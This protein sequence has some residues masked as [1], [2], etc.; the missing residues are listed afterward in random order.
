MLSS[1]LSSTK[2]LAESDILE[3]SSGIY[4]SISISPIF[5]CSR[6]WIIDSGA[7]SH[8]CFSKSS[9]DHLRPVHNVYVTLPNH[10][11]IL[12]SSI[13]FVKLTSEL[14]LENVLFV[15]QFQFNLLFVSTLTKNNSTMSLSFF[16]HTCVI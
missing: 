7:T 13:G 11:W 9:F 10:N 14:V 2:V 16:S 12:V 5:N 1:H 15:P 8:I 6:Y 4:F 3:K